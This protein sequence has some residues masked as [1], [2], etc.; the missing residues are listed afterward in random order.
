VAKRQWKIGGFAL[1]L[2][3]NVEQ[4]E[5]GELTE[6][7]LDVFRRASGSRPLPAT[8]TEPDDS[9][10]RAYRASSN[11]SLGRQLLLLPAIAAVVW[12]VWAGVSGW[13]WVLVFAASPCTV[14]YALG[15]RRA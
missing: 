1:D 13:W 4:K 12:G 5:A 7:E 10:G 9:A 3:V 8:L 2:E 15:T 11:R 14:A 6:E